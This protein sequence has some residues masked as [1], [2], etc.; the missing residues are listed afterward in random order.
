MGISDPQ[1]DQLIEQGRQEGNEAARTKIYK[2]IERHALEQVYIIVPYVYPLRWELV[3][4]HVQG[5][6]VMPSNA[7]LS[8]RGVWLDK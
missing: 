8:V 5:Y 3:W 4:K 1:L 6:E 2:D 7:R